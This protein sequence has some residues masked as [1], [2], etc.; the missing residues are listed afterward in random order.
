M[1]RGGRH[2]E[3]GKEEEEDEE[4]LLEQ[5][6][7]SH[8]HSSSPPRIRRSSRSRKLAS[9]LLESMRGEDEMRERGES[10]VRRTTRP[11]RL[12]HPH[13]HSPA[14]VVSSSSSITATSHPPHDDDDPMDVDVPVVLHNHQH[15]HHSFPPSAAVPAFPRL[16]S[17]P[18]R[19]PT[20]SLVTVS[21]WT[22]AQD[23][24]PLKSRPDVMVLSP[25]SPITPRRS[26]RLLEESI[27]SRHTPTRAGT[28]P[29][30]ASSGGGVSGPSAASAVSD[31]PHTAASNPLRRSTRVASSQHGRGL[32]L[33]A[34]DSP[35]A[36]EQIPTPDSGTAMPCAHV[37]L[38][39]LSRAR[40]W[41]LDPSRWHCEVCETTASALVCL[42][43]PF[44]GCGDE[45]S[46]HMQLHAQ[47]TCHWMCVDVNEQNV[48]CLA[49][50]VPVPLDAVD[51][52]G[53]RFPALR[54]LKRLLD[55][56]SEEL[57]DPPQQPEEIEMNAKPQAPTYPIALGRPRRQSSIFSRP[58]AEFER[59]DMLV[60]MLRRWKL[61]P[62]SKAFTA[63]GP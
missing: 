12:P 38:P 28:S 6:D 51:A 47:D 60:T 17:P 19:R 15:G 21:P 16:P 34:G 23:R 57:Q 55:D 2:K 30:A 53:S 41:L 22:E 48:I 1:R 24:T 10:A 11:R 3:R 18:H 29:G 45:E 33:A 40:E 46:G 36:E 56:L 42:H 43:C 62:L 61:L 52:S 8:S 44:V 39:D 35:A 26:R 32:A 9:W 5:Q 31:T 59:R 13:T 63:Y 20:S 37:R 7:A 49:C 25:S 58:A 4:E 27:S 54:A 14:A 50:N